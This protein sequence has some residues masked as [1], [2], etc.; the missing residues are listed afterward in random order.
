MGSRGAE[1]RDADRRSEDGRVSQRARSWQEM[2]VQIAEQL[3]RQTGADVAT[4]NARIRGQGFT[5]DAAL[6]DRK[7][8][9]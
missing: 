1:A 7:S 5:D 9:V 6:K 3:E 2:Y 4:W 8:V